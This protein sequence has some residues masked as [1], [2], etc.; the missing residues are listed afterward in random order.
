MI[1]LN[2]TFFIQL[3]NFLMV[4]L[5]LNVILYKPI[6]GM[7]RKRA[8]IMSNRVNEIESFSSSAVD[9]MKAYEA[10]LE[11]ARLRAQEIR[12][13]FKEEGYSKEK[14][15]VETASGEAGVMIREARQKVSSEKESAL[16]KL[17]K[18]VEKFATTATDR[19][20]SKA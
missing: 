1:E 2:V 7:L 13:S 12:S 9:K 4:L 5:L 14:E 8:E 17:K 19:I 6:R 11:K 10:E 16:T 3:V 20:L 18:D 15:L